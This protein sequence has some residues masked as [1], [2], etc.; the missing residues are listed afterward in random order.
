MRRAATVVFAT[1][2]EEFV[3]IYALEFS[4]REGFVVSEFAAKGGGKWAAFHFPEF[5]NGDFER[6][7]L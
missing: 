3:A 1:V 5:G 2:V 4:C 7:H 6:V